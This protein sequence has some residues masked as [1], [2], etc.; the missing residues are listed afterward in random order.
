MDF[1]GPRILHL[2]SGAMASP[3][4]REP[5]SSAG[6]AGVRPQGAPEPEGEGTRVDGAPSGAALSGKPKSV[7]AKVAAAND[8]MLLPLV[9][10]TIGGLLKEQ[11]C[12]QNLMHML[13][14]MN[15]RGELPLTPLGPRMRAA[16]CGAFADMISCL[17]VDE[18]SSL[19]TCS[20]G[21]PNNMHAKTCEHARACSMRFKLTGCTDVNY[22]DLVR[23]V[24]AKTRRI[25][26]GKRARNAFEHNSSDDEDN[27]T[28]EED[29]DVAEDVLADDGVGNDKSSQ[30]RSYMAGSRPG[31][32]R[33]EL[34]AR[35]CAVEMSGRCCS[36]IR[37]HDGHVLL[38]VQCTAGE[39]CDAQVVR[40][41]MHKDAKQRQK[42]YDETQ[43]HGLA[44]DSLS[45][46]NLILRMLCKA[47][48]LAV[49][50]KGIIRGEKYPSELGFPS[51][52]AGVPAGATGASQAPA[53]PP[54][55]AA[56]TAPETKVKYEL[57]LVKRLGGL[58]NINIIQDRN[59]WKLGIARPM[60]VRAML[61]L[62]RMLQH[63]LAFLGG[64][65]AAVLCL[66]PHP[67]NPPA[68]GQTPPLSFAE[69]NRANWRTRGAARVY[70]FGPGSSA[71]GNMFLC[72]N[73]ACTKSGKP[74]GPTCGHA[75]SY[76]ISDYAT[77]LAVKGLRLNI[78]E[79]CAK[80]FSASVR[81]V[82]KTCKATDAEEDEEV[83]GDDL[84]F[85]GNNDADLQV[86]ACTVEEGSGDTQKQLALAQ[87]KLSRAEARIGEL[88]QALQRAQQALL[89][90]QEAHIELRQKAHSSEHAA[91]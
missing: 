25:P 45:G 75:I 33:A 58:P 85:G 14:E 81:H 73:S 89:A 32:P 78:V 60:Q 35:E 11:Q 1:A 55:T 20:A 88:E 9:R 12:P 86:P 68:P 90:E 2:L 69:I 61:K 16:L 24:A 65:Q 3:V 46:I 5:D 22:G 17:R 71:L 43:L 31:C 18:V 51:G 44:V 21:H 57:E 49:V 6:V 42:C 19:T 82:P 79:W 39:P 64:A 37:S 4:A 47:E 54:A 84:P 72:G 87:D 48:V 27:D 76:Y 15:G 77:S 23:Q 34:L 7:S 53:P 50:K 83:A 8:A 59:N 70:S 13:F 10:A 40:F 28:D 67:V 66:M 41:G 38:H 63:R 52:F 74:C 26:R 80:H 91:A 29:D 62:V 56:G 36:A 30:R